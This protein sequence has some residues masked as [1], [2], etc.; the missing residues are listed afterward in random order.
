MFTPLD[1]TTFDPSCFNGMAVNPYPTA[2]EM[3][4]AGAN[5]DYNLDVSNFGYNEWRQYDPYNLD[6]RNPWVNGYDLS[7]FDPL[8]DFDPSRVHILDNMQAMTQ[9][10]V[11][12]SMPTG[13]DSSACLFQNPYAMPM[14]MNQDFLTAGLFPNMPSP[15]MAHAM[16]LISDQDYDFLQMIGPQPHS[17][18][19]VEPSHNSWADAQHEMNVKK[20]NESDAI[21][22][23]RDLAVE[24][25]QDA[26]RAGDVEEML[27]WENEANKKQD[28][29]YTL[30]DTPRYTPNAK[31]P[32]ID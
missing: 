24:H 28:E 22:S 8:L 31:A 21:E 11:F 16:G 25:Y 32:G 23:A 2:A 12:P 26:K 7:D 9:A 29:L 6:M 19:S 5:I 20:L 17:D 13:A 27:K 14:D 10:P 18:I 4:A 1:F 30:W 3:S 15:E